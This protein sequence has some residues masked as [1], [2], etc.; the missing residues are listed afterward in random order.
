MTKFRVTFVSPTEFEWL[1][2]EIEYDGQLICRIRNERP[3][4]ALEIEFN[5]NTYVDQT[6]RP[7]L[8]LDEFVK[9]LAEVSK[10]V[11]DCRTT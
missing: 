3:D 7:I 1:A 2:A 8:P 6:M 11:A 5:F 9:L 4:R 10:E